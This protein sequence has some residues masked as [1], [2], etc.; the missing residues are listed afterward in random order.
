[1]KRSDDEKETTDKVKHDVSSTLNSIIDSVPVKSR[2]KNH[3]DREAV[4]RHKVHKVLGRKRTYD[5]RS[6][7]K[8]L[9]FITCVFECIVIIQSE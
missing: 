7:G 1:M 3:R 9:R 5:T 8:P 6:K 4:A 2:N